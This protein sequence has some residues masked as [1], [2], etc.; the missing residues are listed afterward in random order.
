MVLSMPR[1][2]KHPKTGT[3]WYRQRTPAAHKTI[4]VGK[5]V[6]VTIDGRISQPKIGSTIQVSL[7][8]KDV[9]E[10]KRL[11]GEAQSQFDK[12]WL[13]F[14]DAPVKLSHKQIVAL[15]GEVYRAWKL[16]LEDEPGSAASWAAKREQRERWDGKPL[17]PATQRALMIDPPRTLREQWGSWV[18]GA[19]LEHHLT[20]DDETYQR[21]LVEFDRALRDVFDLLERRANGDYSP[22]LT[23]QRFPTVEVTKRVA[24]HLVKVGGEKPDA[25]TLSA[26]LDHKQATQSKK[27]RTF[28]TYR[29]KIADLVRLIGH[30]DATT[31]TRDDVRK[32]RDTLIGRGLA[33]KTIND[34]YL[35]ALKSTLRHGVKEFSL[36]SN[37]ADLIRDQ[38]DAPTT[39]G[40]KGYSA[41]QAKVILAATFRGSQKSLSAPHQRAVFWVP[42]IS[43]YTGLR[44]SEITQFQ[45]RHLR[46][47]D[48][49]RF[50][51]ITPEDGSTKGGNAWTMAIHPH[52]IEM[53]I[54][55]MFQAIGEG[56]AFYTPYPA[57]TD[58]KAL[59]DHR[60]G[61]SAGKVANWITEEL[62]IAAPGG[63]PN[64]A[65]R[66][67]FTSL[68]RKHRVDK[69]PRDFMLGSRPLTDAREGYG[70]WPP[71]VIDAEIRKLPRF[72]VAMGDWRPT[73]EKVRPE[74][75]R[76]TAKS[77]EAQRPTLRLRK[78]RVVKE[79]L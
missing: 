46:D 28:D 70:D 75:I 37:V 7:W 10:A 36:A 62:G 53:G 5:T 51:L 35:A 31:I 25:L 69:E 59:E 55:D 4:A 77:P 30:E 22:D 49:V 74:P 60:A 56:P 78:P 45:G 11:A 40:G 67:S 43:A 9:A 24:K 68:C 20:V 14:N 52:L 71:E 47:E 50:L 32:W 33:T 76:N 66:H 17:P 65:W 61:E 73:L 16:M 29:A 23:A 12:V 26:L 41:E 54:I 21:L 72:D 58:L 79:R 48:G 15:S 63:R 2:F 27:S 64:H 44:V 39:E 34:Q 42:W 38:R 57:G 1:P 13:S 19:L 8:T 3:Y 6:T 18:D